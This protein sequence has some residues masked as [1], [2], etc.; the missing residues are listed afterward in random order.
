MAGARN[1]GGRIDRAAAYQEIWGGIALPPSPHYDGGPS[2]L[3][4][5]VPEGPEAGG[6]WFGAGMQRTALPCTFMIGPEG[7]F[8]V[9]AGTWVPLHG[10]VAGWVEAV[11]LADRARRCAR[12]VTTVT[13][14]AVEALQLGRF[15]PVLE[16][17]GRSDTWWRGADSLVAVYRGEAECM[18]APQC[19]TAAVCSG[20]DEWGLQR[21]RCLKGTALRR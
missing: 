12:T 15:E 21:T 18:S 16:V 19:R 14:E 3:S 4:A 11:A 7:E 9:H 17:A 20:L 6:W 2:S 5:D 8:G 13:G 1:P 10:S